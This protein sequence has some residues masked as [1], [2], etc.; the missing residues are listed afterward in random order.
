MKIRIYSLIFACLTGF[1][2][3]V[4]ADSPLTSTEFSAAYTSEAIVMKASATQGK[5]TAE[6][7]S[8]LVQAGNP[9]ELKVAV[10]NQLG[11]KG[12]GSGNSG[13]LLSYLY[14]HGFRDEEDLLRNGPGDLLLCIG[15]LQAMDNYYRA[16]DAMK[17][18]ERPQV[19]SS[20][21]YTCQL[22]SALIM[23]QRYL[24]RYQWCM[25]YR[26]TDHV[27][28][29]LFLIKDMKKEAVEVIF[30]YMDIYQRHCNAVTQEN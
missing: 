1:G 20:R 30:R 12:H 18:I 28:R 4:Y 3:K 15:Y 11:W 22:I 19:I 9:L 26:E 24:N 7:I 16:S 23:A 17:Y 2:S 27:R 5:L 29:N 8:Y 6:L 10:I 21:S 14:A 25:V 13:R